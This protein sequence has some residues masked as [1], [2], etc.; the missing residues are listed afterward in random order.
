MRWRWWFQELADK[1]KNQ[2]EKKGGGS[3]GRLGFGWE[4]V[5]DQV[6]C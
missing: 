5:R 1:K 6:G 3:V 4:R 2:R